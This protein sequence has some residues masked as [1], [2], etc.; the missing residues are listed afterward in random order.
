MKNKVRV[1]HVL[2]SLELGGA[3]SRTMEILRTINRNKIQ[4]DFVVHQ[5]TN[6]FEKEAIDLGAKVYKINRFNILNY[7]NYKKK[8]VDIL[9]TQNYDIIHGHTLVTGFIYFQIA[10][11][12]N[13]DVRIAHSRSGSKNGFIR[14]KLINQSVEHANELLA[15]SQ[16]SGDVYFGSKRQFKVFKSPFNINKYKFNLNERKTIRKK[17][18]ISD[19]QTVYGHVG[20]FHKVKNHK[21]L[22]DIFKFLSLE[23]DGYLLLIGSGK[24]LKNVFKYAKKKEIYNKIVHISQTDKVEKYLA[25]MD[26]FIFPSIHEG[27]PGSVIEAQ[28]SGLPIFMSDSISDEVVL[29]ENVYQ[30]KLNDGCRKWSQFILSIDGND[31]NERINS[32]H[33]INFNP[34]QL[35]TIVRQYEHLYLDKKSRQC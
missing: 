18:S 20:R 4:F 19:V 23:K 17:Y 34:Y 8:W 35:S 15:V 31:L 13:I 30:L 5:K 14:E 6:F 1:L 7:F 11:A 32:I 16:L 28:I 22:L 3:E 9:K 26:F 33:N 25:A 10:K 2:G 24:E 21:F 12:Y 27:F 29:N